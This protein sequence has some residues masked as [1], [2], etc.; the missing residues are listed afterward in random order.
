M[1]YIVHGE[2]LPKSRALILNHY[3]KSGLESKV[4]VEITDI[5][6]EKLYELTHTSDIFGSPQYVVLDV[7]K[8]GRLNVEKY[9]EVLEKTPESVVVVVLSSKALGKMNAFIKESARLN[10]KVI[11]NALEPES[12]IFK[13]VDAVYSKNRTKAYQELQKLLKEDKDQFYIFAMILYGLRTAKSRFAAN[14]SESVVKNLFTE[15]YRLDKQVKTSDIDSETMLTLA[16]EKV[17]NS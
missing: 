7:S 6:P 12:N 14:F 3:K 11:E 5:T 4:E 9:I 16:I 2:D 1:I 15:L 17:L 10:A 13:F 8:A